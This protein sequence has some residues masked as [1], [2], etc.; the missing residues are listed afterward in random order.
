MTVKLTTATRTVTAM[1]RNLSLLSKFRLVDRQKAK[2][3]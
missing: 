3:G 1:A 2:T